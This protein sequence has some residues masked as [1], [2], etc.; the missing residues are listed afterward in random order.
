[1]W[2]DVGIN[3]V[4]S[5]V[6]VFTVMFFLTFDLTSSLIILV[7]I[8]MIIGDMMGMMYWWDISLNAV[9]LVNLVMVSVPGDGDGYGECSW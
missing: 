2:T 1:M 7:T 4:I 6:S 8:C 5:V 9:S 3:L